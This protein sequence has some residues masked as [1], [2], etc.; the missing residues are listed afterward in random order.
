MHN[1]K[2]LIHLTSIL[3]N[4]NTDQYIKAGTVWTLGMIG[5]HSYEHARYI[6]DCG[7]ITAIMNVRLDLRKKKES[8]ILNK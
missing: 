3:K 5:Q 6:N 7:A 2:V 1:L 8:H 4:H